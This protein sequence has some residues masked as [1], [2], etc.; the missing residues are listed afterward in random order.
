MTLDQ[1]SYQQRQTLRGLQWIGGIGRRLEI[2]EAAGLDGTKVANALTALRKEGAVSQAEGVK[3]ALTDLGS[4]LLATDTAR[5]A[6]SDEPKAAAQPSPELPRQVEAPPA[7][8]PDPASFRQA[9]DAEL[10]RLAQNPAPADFSAD[11]AVFLCAA[12]REQFSD[13]PAISA[14]FGQMAAYWER[15][16]ADKT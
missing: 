10:R 1:L 6:D 4:F 11:D 9:L 14:M 2:A 12:M 3:W 16:N 5:A 15:V 8:V 7:P 13:M